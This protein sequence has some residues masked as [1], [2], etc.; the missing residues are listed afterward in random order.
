MTIKF[1]TITHLNDDQKDAL[2]EI[3]NIAM[4]RAGDS[5]ARILDAFVQLSIPRIR[6]VEA[7]QLPEV[8]AEMIGPDTIV[9][10]VRQPFYNHLHGEA[11]VVYD[12]NG[13]NELADMMGHEDSLDERAEEELLLDIG[14][15]LAGAS[16]NGVA[17]QLSAE[18]TFSAP[19]ILAR[20]SPL[21]NL[22]DPEEVSWTHAL[23]IEVNFT[24]EGRD[25]RSH[26]LIMLTED[27]IN[28]LRQ[29]ID[30]FMEAC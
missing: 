7:S 17:E 28:V 2:G 14:N 10:A 11:I 21:D 3:V 19:S 8:L 1:K 4:G 16:L 30:S 29:D 12:H 25:F 20:R 5:L 27:S 18:V 6:L 22:L 26:L 13:C 23:L 24:L 15:I 9:S